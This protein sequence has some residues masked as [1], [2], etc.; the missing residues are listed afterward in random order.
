MIWSWLYPVVTGDELTSRPLWHT[1]VCFDVQRVLY[2]GTPS[3]ADTL[4]FYPVFLKSNFG[5]QG[6]YV[7]ICG[8]CRP[9]HSYPVW[10][11]VLFPIFSTPNRK[12]EEASTVS[13][14]D[15]ALA[16]CVDGLDCLVNLIHLRCSAFFAV[17]WPIFQLF[18]LYIP[19]VLGW[20]GIGSKWVLEMFN[21][22]MVHIYYVVPKR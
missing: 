3:V 19:L 2:T 10:W 20:A 21:T 7:H 4:P 9:L 13:L 18:C 1:G 22:E 11:P 6:G 14:P 5:Q 8:F 16:W 17:D 12:N 15:F